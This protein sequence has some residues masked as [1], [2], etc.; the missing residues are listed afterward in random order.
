MLEPQRPG[1]VWPAVQLWWKSMALEGTESNEK[2]SFGVNFPKSNRIH[3]KVRVS[4]KRFNN[5]PRNLLR[6]TGVG[7]LTTL[8]R[9]ALVFS[10][11]GLPSK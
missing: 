8:V 1:M 3:V 6:V 4:D 9:F 11:A 2:P 10:S 5:R 7:F